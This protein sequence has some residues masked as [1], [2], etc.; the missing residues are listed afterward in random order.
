ML[1]PDGRFLVIGGSDRAPTDTL[2]ALDLNAGWSLLPARLSRPLS[3]AQ[4]VYVGGPVLVIGGQTTT[5]LILGTAELVR[6]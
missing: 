3:L 1:L 6:P 5:G 4:A 2:Y